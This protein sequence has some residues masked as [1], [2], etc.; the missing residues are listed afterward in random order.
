VDDDD[1]ERGVVL[2]FAVGDCPAF[3]RPEMSTLPSTAGQPEFVSSVVV[4]IPELLSN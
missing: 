1:D 2:P 3:E 4:M